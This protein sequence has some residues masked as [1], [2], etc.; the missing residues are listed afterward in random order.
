M[1]KTKLLLALLAP[2]FA[3]RWLINYSFA[4]Q[5]IYGAI[6]FVAGVAP[7]ALLFAPYIKPNTEPIG[8]AVLGI[9]SGLGTAMF[10][11]ITVDRFMV[12][13]RERL[14]GQQ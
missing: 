4:G 9:V 6:L 5:A 12:S 14:L 11:G 3:V 1:N 13:T 2:Y 7:V 8:I 10:F